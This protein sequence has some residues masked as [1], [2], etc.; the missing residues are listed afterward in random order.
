MLM[1]DA[2]IKIGNNKKDDN[3]CC[4]KDQNPLKYLSYCF[5]TECSMVLSAM[6]LLS[7]F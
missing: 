7:I 4:Y 6:V 1:K 3:D 2:K 5:C